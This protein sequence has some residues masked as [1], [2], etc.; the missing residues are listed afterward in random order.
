MSKTPSQADLREL[1]RNVTAFA[2]KYRVKLEIDFAGGGEFQIVS[3]ERQSPNRGSG[4]VVLDYVL[5]EAKRVGADVLLTVKN[6]EPRLIKFYEAA[7][8]KL[9]GE[10]EEG[11]DPVMVFSC[12]APSKRKTVEP[13]PKRH[14]PSFQP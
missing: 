5:S 14:T 8:F 7:G 9:L 4:R 12:G 3:I 2:A 6:S 1:E 11:E 10:P 13:V